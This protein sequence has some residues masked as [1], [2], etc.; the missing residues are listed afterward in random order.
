MS[1]KISMAQTKT[2]FCKNTKFMAVI[3][4]LN[5]ENKDQL[6]MIEKMKL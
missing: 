6:K 1:K 2:N 5:F 4:P 3:Q